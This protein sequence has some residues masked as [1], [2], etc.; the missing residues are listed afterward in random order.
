MV[1]IE[2]EP[3]GHFEYCMGFLN[4]LGVTFPLPVRP[5]RELFTMEVTISYTT[6]SIDYELRDI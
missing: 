4:K 2:R 3:S 6:D 1:L 5:T